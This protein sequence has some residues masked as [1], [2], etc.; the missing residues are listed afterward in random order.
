MSSSQ[1]Q[2]D[3]V[4]MDLEMTGLEV[5][6]DKIL[7][8]SCIITDK[9]L[10]VKSKE[11]SFA[12]SHPEQVYENMNEWCIKQHNES[13][14]IDKCRQ[15]EIKPEQ[16]EN[17]ILSFLKENIPERKCPLAGNTIYMDRIFIQKYFPAVD[18]YLD[19][20]IIDVSSIKE[21]ATRWCPE[22]ADAAPKKGFAHRSLEDINESIAE[23]QYY[24]EHLFK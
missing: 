17:I 8:V 18:Q 5:E 22:I 23:L 21:L 7:E 6:K 19:Y 1:N 9:D 10:K 13:G 12:I 24:K 11:L 15:S 16:A 4:W 2:S 3:I 20:R 14:L